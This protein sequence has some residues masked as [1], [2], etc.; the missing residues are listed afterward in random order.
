[1]VGVVDDRQMPD[2]RIRK[3]LIDR[4]DRAAGNAGLVEL[5]LPIGGGL[6]GE[7]RLDI[8]IELAAVVRACLERL[9]FRL[10]DHLRRAECM[11]EA[12][13]DLARRGD[14]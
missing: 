14:V 13:I 3:H 9:V 2:L 11:A 12:R 7:D 1:M 4:V 5:L 8:G 10:V 6:R